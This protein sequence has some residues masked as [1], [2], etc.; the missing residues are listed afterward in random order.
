MFLEKGFTIDE[1]IQIYDIIKYSNTY[2]YH[3]SNILK[4]IAER[5]ISID[6]AM[7]LIKLINSPNL[8]ES[9]IQELLRIKKI[10]SQNNIETEKILKT[11]INRNEI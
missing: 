11:L 10:L 1:I 7:F 4:M 2:N 3:R 8:K 9:T 6:E 5:K